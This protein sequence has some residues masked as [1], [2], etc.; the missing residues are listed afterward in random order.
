M[1]SSIEAQYVAALAQIPRNYTQTDSTKLIGRYQPSFDTTAQR[2]HQVKISL[3]H[4]N[5]SLDV[6]GMSKY[7][8]ILSLARS[9]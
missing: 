6:T 4:Y 5:Q 1:L 3:L 7:S 2:S 9:T 8:T